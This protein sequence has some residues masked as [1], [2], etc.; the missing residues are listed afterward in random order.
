MELTLA[1]ARL[2]QRVDVEL[3]TP[4]IPPPHGMVVNRPS[5]GVRVLTG[6][7]HVDVATDVAT[8]VGTVARHGV[9]PL[10]GP[11]SRD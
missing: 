2:A 9:L 8:D 3:A 10:A 5:G 6:R 1:I 7:P 4:E 11:Q